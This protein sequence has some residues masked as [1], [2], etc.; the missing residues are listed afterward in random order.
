MQKCRPDDFACVL[1][2]APHVV[3]VFAARGFQNCPGRLDWCRVARVPVVG[4]YG[5]SLNAIYSKRSLSK[6]VDSWILR[7]SVLPGLQ[8]RS[9]L[10]VELWLRWNGRRGAPSTHCCCARRGLEKPQN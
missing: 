9:L 7:P 10:T 4:S 5:L 2:A 6:A 8:V 1:P 3:G